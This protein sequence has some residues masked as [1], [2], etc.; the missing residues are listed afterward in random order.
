M[1]VVAPP[2]Y[3]TVKHARLL[4][5]ME[6][7]IA[8]VEEG[9]RTGQLGNSS[10]ENASILL[11]DGDGNTRGTIGPDN[12]GFWG[13]LD[14]NNPN[15]PPQPTA[16]T[17][18]SFFN[19]LWV[20]HDGT[21]ADGAGFP[22][23]LSH[24]NVYVA[25]PSL[26]YTLVGTIPCAQGKNFPVKFP[27]AALENQEYSVKVAAV[28]F[29]SKESVHSA[30]ATA[31]PSLVVGQD[32]LT[33]IID[34]TKLAAEA[35][36]EASLAAGA[37]T[38]TKVADNAIDTPQLTAGAVRAD[39]IAAAQIQASH[40]IT[41][42]VTAEKIEALAITGDKIAAN[43]IETGKIAAGAVTAAKLDANL[44]IA[45]RIIAGDPTGT[46]V[47]MTPTQGIQ[48]FKDD[49]DTRTFW[50]DAATGAAFFMGEL[51]T[52]LS[53]TARVQIN[54]SG[55]NPDTIRFWNNATE[56]G[57]LT[58]ETAPG[59]TAAIIMRSSGT[60]PKAAVGCYPTEAF[61][62]SQNTTISISA[63]SALGAA[64]NIWGGE[65]N[66]DGRRVSGTGNITF[67]V[68]NS[69]GTTLTDVY[70]YATGANQPAMR[71]TTTD[72]VLFWSTTDMYSGNFV[73]DPR[74]FAGAPYV[75]VSSASTKKNIRAKGRIGRKPDGTAA[76][77]REVSR[78]FEAKN[79]NYTNE[80]ADTEPEP[81]R[82]KEIRR[83][84]RTDSYGKG[85]VGDDGQLIMDEVE[86]IVEPPPV[87][88]PHLFPIAE[89]LMVIA[90]ELVRQDPEKP[91]GLTISMGDIQGFLLNLCREQEA[92]LVSL[93]ADVDLL[94]NR[95]R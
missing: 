49:G 23:D 11:N 76:T 48:A 56:Y 75:V 17:L 19:G 18:S 67:R 33:G 82:K 38:K 89:E 30:V 63:C 44:V 2:H 50:L 66:I 80:R 62:A 85:I 52:G 83:E 45:G 39:K 7:R 41:G 84:A 25:P 78:A 37:V 64:M 70:I 86:V 87:T 95:V 42:A 13:F 4:S 12:K 21:T 47:E 20:E 60:N 69:G 6:M 29:S 16:P 68:K 27:I 36:T 59:S 93:R 77:Y 28:N 88:K 31:T 55:T 54:P 14:T 26:E 40:L 74:A 94:K 9:L 81:P 34:A 90:P 65:V 5:D 71:R 22:S 15:P 24:F 32:I 58:A 53:G 73:G 46:R 91:G 51:T 61:I 35:V 57:T 8:R 79:W 92:E 72:Q 43:S 1:A 3:E 10:L